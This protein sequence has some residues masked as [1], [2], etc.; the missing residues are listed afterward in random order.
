MPRYSV[1]AVVLKSINFQDSDKIYTLF[2]KDK[3]KII[4]SGKG[5]RKI[6]SRRGGNLDTLN[7]I[8]LGISESQRGFKTITEVKT[9]NSFRDLKSS[10]GNSAKGFY[11]A[12]LVYKLLDESAEQND[13]FDLLVSSLTKLDK[14]LNNEVSRVNSFE[15]KLMDLLGYGMY[16]DQ[17]AKTSRPYDGSWDT[18]KFNASI[19][20]LISDPSVP[21]IELTKGTADLLHALK[22]KRAIP[23]KLLEDASHIKEA[24][25]LLKAY[26]KD[27]LD[28]DIR[29]ARVF[30]EI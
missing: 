17:C 5:V 29:T 11:L 2:A 15:I 19:G 6:S 13:V 16:L 28:G 7:H 20:G 9:V 30:G 21:G 3:G 1:E 24:D 23:K 10:L 14:H 4:A 26:I 27:I 25:R 12:E 22:T 18:I 8:V